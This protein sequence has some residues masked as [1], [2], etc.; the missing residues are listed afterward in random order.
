MTLCLCVTQQTF[1][2]QIFVFPS[3]CELP[4]SP[5]KFQTTTLNILFYLKLKMV[6]EVRDSAIWR[7]YLVFPSLFQGVFHIRMHAKS[8]TR[9]PLCVTPWTA[10]QQAPMFVGFS[11]QQYWKWVAV[12][13][14]KGSSQPRD[15]TQVSYVSYIRGKGR[16]VLYQ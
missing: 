15:R 2:Y 13:S 6:F 8:L 10:A 3:P 11:R 16:H 4:S 9:V 12:P 7:S 14:S 1:I 5:L